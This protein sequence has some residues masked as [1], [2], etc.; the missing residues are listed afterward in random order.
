M[1]KQAYQQTYSNSV[2]NIR[3]EIKCRNKNVKHTKN[4]IYIK[5]KA[6]SPDN[7]V[8]CKE[9]NMKAFKSYCFSSQTRIIQ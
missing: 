9:K 5:I 3:Y 1:Q 6:S 7:T 4:A 8:I 2:K